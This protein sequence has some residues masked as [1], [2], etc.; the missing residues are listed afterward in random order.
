M[1]DARGRSV[2]WSAGVLFVALTACGGSD[3]EGSV[4]RAANAEGGATA[5]PSVDEPLDLTGIVQDKGDPDNAPVVVIE[6]S[7][8]GCVFCARFHSGSYAALRDEFVASGDVIWRY[9]PVTIGGFPNGDGAASTALCVADQTSFPGIRDRL[10]GARDIW[11]R[12]SA[13]ESRET[14][15]GFAAE[16]SVDLPQWEACMDDPDT[17]RRLDM[18]NRAAGAAG[19]G[20]TPSFLVQGFMVQGAPA[21]ENFQEALRQLVADVRAGIP[22]DEG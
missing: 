9:V 22:A 15:R 20:G 13:A 2:I 16:Q 8:F 6:F 12:Q 7:D 1:R 21:L 5:S 17:R 19:V 18:A 11:L 4:A 3:D 14:F 10:Y